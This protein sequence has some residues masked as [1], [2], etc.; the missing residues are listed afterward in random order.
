MY[1]DKRIV[2]WIAG[3]WRRDERESRKLQKGRF[4]Q[5]VQLQHAPERSGC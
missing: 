3:T 5:N 2:L 4:S 1:M